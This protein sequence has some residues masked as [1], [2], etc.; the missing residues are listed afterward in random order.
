MF[1]GVSESDETPKEEKNSQNKSIPTQDGESNNASDLEKKQ[2]PSTNTENR[3]NLPKAI[4]HNSEQT[5]CN[6]LKLISLLLKT[7][8]ISIKY[9]T[10]C[11]FILF[12]YLTLKIKSFKSRLSRRFTACVPPENLKL[13]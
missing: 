13:A 12:F 1:K 8:E 9:Y 3:S 10:K 5:L 6:E 4:L 11:F 2:L 7:H